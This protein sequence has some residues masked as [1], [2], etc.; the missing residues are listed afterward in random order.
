MRKMATQIANSNLWED[1]RK[2]IMQS[3]RVVLSPGHNEMTYRKALEKA[4]KAVELDPYMFINV[5]VLGTA[6]YRIGAYED[7]VATFNHANEIRDNTNIGHG[8][9]VEGFRAM[10]LHQLGRD[11]E[12]NADLQQLRENIN[13]NWFSE[14]DE[15]FKGWSTV[16]LIVVVEVEKLFAGEDRTLFS[17]WE[18]IEENRLDEASELIEKARQSK[19][20]DYVSCMEG[21]IKLI[22]ALRNRK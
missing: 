11:K 17:I 12:A 20:A 14:E 10:A 15:R 21:A 22:E 2:L 7:A 3:G 18:L 5:I 16:F 9:I 1:A 8:P 13:Q 4:E 19:N 6:Q